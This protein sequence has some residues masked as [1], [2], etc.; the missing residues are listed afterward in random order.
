VHRSLLAELTT[1]HDLQLHLGRVATILWNYGATFPIPTLDAYE[2]TANVGFEFVAELPGLR[3][4]KPAIIKMS[5]IWETAGADGF[6]RRE[7]E[8]D[9]VEHPLDR[10]R[11]FHGHHPDHFAREFDVLVHE[12]CEEV[13]GQPTCDHY[14]GLPVDGYEAIRRFASLWGQPAPLGCADLRC[15]SG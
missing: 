12:H 2:E 15:M 7:Y 9:F 10:R 13:L 11:A 5:E 6:R 1:I 4:P 14:F 3:S 8:Y